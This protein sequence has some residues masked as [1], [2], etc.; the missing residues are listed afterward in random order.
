[1]KKIFCG[2]ILL[3]GSLG[4]QKAFGYFPSPESLFRNAS[5]PEISQNAVV[6]NFEIEKVSGVVGQGLQAVYGAEEIELDKSAR[7]PK[8]YLKLVYSF[9]KGRATKLTQLI[10]RSKSFASSSLILLKTLPSFGN[11][12]LRGGVEDI[13]KGLIYSVL[14]SLLLNDGKMMLDFLRKQGIDLPPNSQLVNKEKLAL[15]V[16]IQKY[17]QKIK[18]N[19]ALKESLPSPLKPPQ[20]QKRQEVQKLLTAN[21]FNQ[22]P[23]V[24]LLR[25]G[26]DFFWM[27]Q[28]PRFQSFHTNDD[29]KLVSIELTSR[30]G[31]LELYC[32]NFRAFDGAY[33]FPQ[34]MYFKDLKGQFFKISM[35]SM[36][37]FNE[38]PQSES[39]RL[40]K[41]RQALAKN[42]RA[43]HVAIPS[44]IF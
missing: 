32:Q 44:F 39:K 26:S 28:K 2:M 31:K 11:L 40:T 30:A 9:N 8:L 34:V 27:I 14:N 37:Y 41:Y 33:Q 19:P 38:S 16:N 6:A 3:F 10:Y 20:Y 24:K 21:F 22:D 18:Y 4:G 17:Y 13:E 15:L 25:K 7:N 35:I 23:S 12:I 1:M 5:N 43:S 36:D 42:S 29:R